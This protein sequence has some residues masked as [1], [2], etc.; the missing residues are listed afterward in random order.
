MADSGKLYIKETIAK[1]TSSD[2]QKIAIFS[3]VGLAFGA[4]SGILLIVLTIL[5]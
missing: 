3:G 4:R 5:N 1:F 2:Y